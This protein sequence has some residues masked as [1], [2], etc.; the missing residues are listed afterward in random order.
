MDNEHL[1]QK[2]LNEPSSLEKCLMGWGIRFENEP[3]N[4]E[5]GNVENGTDRANKQHEFCDTICL[6]FSRHFYKFRIYIVPRDGEQRKIINQIQG[7]NLYR[8]HWYKRYKCA[9]YQD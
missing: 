6:P 7:T 4:D 2:T 9:H 3:K 8:K 1:R 5:R